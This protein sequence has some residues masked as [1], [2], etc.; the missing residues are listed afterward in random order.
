M[1]KVYRCLK[2]CVVVIFWWNFSMNI[3]IWYLKAGIYMYTNITFVCHSAGFKWLKYFQIYIFVSCL[4]A[5][6][7]FWD[8]NYLFQE[9][10]YFKRKQRIES[11]FNIKL[12]CILDEP[13][14][15][16]VGATWSKLLS[17]NFG[18]HWFSCSVYFVSPRITASESPRM[19]LV[20]FL[21]IDSANVKFP[22][23]WSSNV[24]QNCCAAKL[25]ILCVCDYARTS[26]LLSLTCLLGVEGGGG[27]M[28]ENVGITHRYLAQND[29]WFDR[30]N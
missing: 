9:F 5:N 15:R 7:R 10:A 13:G 18:L 12:K 20:I 28:W 11:L 8:F 19:V 6:F 24:Q 4:Y 21:L 23:D 1:F 22:N 14:T 27:E 3:A 30:K 26:D 16:F 29:W 17:V 2:H 25:C